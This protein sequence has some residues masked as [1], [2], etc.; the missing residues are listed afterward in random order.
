MSPKVSVIIPVYNVEPYLRECLDSVVNQTLQEIEIICVDDG[1]T[2]NSRAILQ[3]YGN[4]DKRITI[5]TQENLGSGKARNLA[6]AQASG[7]FVAFMDADDFYPNAMVL[8]RLY[9][10][11]QRTGAKICG[12]VRVTNVNGKHSKNQ[13]FNRHFCS[14]GMLEYAD[15]QF[16]YHYQRFIFSTDLLKS[17]N[18]LFPDYL[19][20]QDPPFF[21]RAMIAAEQ[22]YAITDEVYCYRWGH[23]NINWSFRRVNDMVRGLTDNLILSREHGLSILHIVCVERMNKDFCATICKSLQ[24][25][26]VELLEL[27]ARFNQMISTELLLPQDSIA[28]PNYIITPLKHLLGGLNVAPPRKGLLH[29][30]PTALRYCREHGMRATIARVVLELKGRVPKKTAK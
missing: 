30:F 8:E 6:L 17:N 24:Q 4:K 5:L 12:G 15:V 20:F 10:S 18:I 13:E 16:D 23:Q 26:N 9:N 28:P 11:A 2:D 19:R 3:E 21:V 27:L 22:F 25:G 29:K 7:E 14:E 1:S